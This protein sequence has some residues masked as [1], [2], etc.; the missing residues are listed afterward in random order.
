VRRRGRAAAIAV[1]LLALG[2]LVT[3]AQAQG[4]SSAVLYAFGIPR[5]KLVSETNVPVAIGG[6]LTVTYHGDTGTGCA[7]YGLCAYSGTVVARPTSGSFDV[8]TY[9][10][11][12][13]IRHM[14]ALVFEPRISGYT[15]AA[16]VQRASPGGQ[17]GTC[18]DAS[19]SDFGGGFPTQLARGGSVT[20]RLLAAG[21]SLLATRCAGPLDGD[22]QS[23]SPAATVSLRKLERGGVSID[24]TGTRPF[25]AHGFAG[26][27][28]STV[29]LKLGAGHSSPSNPSFPAGIKTARIRTV[30]EKL[31]LEKISGDFGA[32][33]SGSADPVVCRLLDSCGLTGTLS[34]ASVPREVSASAI[35]MGPASH[36]YGEFLTALGLRPG[37]RPS[38]ISVLVSVSWG[39]DV[40]STVQQ[41]GVTCTDTAPG[42]G[43]AVALAE[44][45]HGGTL[46]GS[47]AS[48][49]SWRTRCPGPSLANAAT[50]LS[51]SVPAGALRDPR[52]RIV[53]RARSGVGDDGYVI[54]PHGN[55]SLVLRR[56]RISQ[57]VQVEPTG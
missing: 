51:A 13:R 12:G 35:A 50:L 17:S 1:A 41:A 39:A 37:P 28:T 57:S 14:V 32:A 6:Q 56:G 30:I 55:L 24:L 33:L 38:G 2:T 49:G 44:P 7:A 3:G 53:L 46:V 26:T 4:S 22:L 11:A 45:A 52:L 29:V 20:V 8:E 31:K 27:V 40:T 19:A 21:G 16:V 18:V 15:T 54:S 42:G 36:P 9:R 25:A 48:A 47:S 23:V 5:G 34:L 10:Y 43:I